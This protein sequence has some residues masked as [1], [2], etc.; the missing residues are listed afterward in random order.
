[1]RLGLVGP[2]NEARTS[3]VIRVHN[4]IRIDNFRLFGRSFFIQ[5][6]SQ[7]VVT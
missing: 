7:V 5:Q 4:Y 2:G 3:L 1:M 6:Q